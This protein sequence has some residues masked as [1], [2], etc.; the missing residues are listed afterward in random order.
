MR[1][2]IDPETLKLLNE[3]ASTLG[4]ATM[5]KSFS[6]ETVSFNSLLKMVLIDY[7]KEAARIEELIKS[8]EVR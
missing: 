2:T 8:Y 7:L 5:N 4:V 1:I 3:A 6:R